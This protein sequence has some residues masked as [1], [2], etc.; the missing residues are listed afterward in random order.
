MV[1]FIELNCDVTGIDI[2][3]NKIENAKLFLKEKL[4]DHNATIIDND[5]YKVDASSIGSYDI[6]ILRDVIEHIPDQSRFL[7]HMRSFLKPDGIIF[8][9][10]PPWRMPF[11]GHQQICK[12][13]LLSKLPYFHLLP[14]FMYKNIL[15][16][17]GEKENRI[18]SLMEIKETQISI[19][20]FNRII[21]ENKLEFAKRNYFLINPNYNIKFGLEPKEQFA[22]IS[23]IPYLRD[24][25]TTCVYCVVRKSA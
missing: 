7:G 11:G 9:G 4:P 6:I 10:F 19:N 22:V 23:A 20:R 8:F 14:N 25:L 12:S 13:K 16:L 2:N 3:T 1:P 17:F 24:F 15:K 21:S 5:I 18:E